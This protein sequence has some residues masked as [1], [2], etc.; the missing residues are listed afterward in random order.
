MEMV[1]RERD[2]DDSS[3]GRVGAVEGD[4]EPEGDDDED[5]ELL[6]P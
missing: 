1:E 5:A 3:T 4:R 2:S 6:P